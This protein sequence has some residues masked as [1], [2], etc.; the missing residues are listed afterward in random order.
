MGSVGEDDA[1]RF[2]SLSYL[3]SIGLCAKKLEAPNFGGWSDDMIPYNKVD[4]VACH[5]LANLLLPNIAANAK[6]KVAYAI[7]RRTIAIVSHMEKVGTRIDIDAVNILAKEVS[8]NVI[9]LDDEI[10]KHAPAAIGAAI[11]YKTKKPEA[12]TTAAR[13]GGVYAKS[14][15]GKLIFTGESDGHYNYRKIVAFNPS[16]QEHRVAALKHI[17][18]WVPDKFS[19]KTGKP[20]CDKGVLAKL[21]DEFVFA[22]MLHKYS[23]YNKLATTYI[24]AFTKTDMGGR[25]HPSFLLT[26]TRTSRL[27]SRNPN[28]QNIPKDRCRSLIVASPGHKLVCV[29]L[30]QIELRILAWL[31]ANLINNFYLWG[32]YAQGADVHSSNMKLLETTNRRLAKNGIFLKIYGGGAAKLAVTV[33]IPLQLAVDKLALM[34]ERMPFIDELAACV[35]RSAMTADGNTIYTM[36]GHKLC[37]PYLNSTDRS[38]AAYAKRQYF[39]AIIQGTQADIIKYIM[40]ILFHERRITERFGARFLLQIHDELVFEVPEANVPLVSQN[41]DEVCNNKTMLPGLPIHGVSGWGDSWKEASAHSEE[42]FDA[43]KKDLYHLTT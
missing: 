29:D 11:R 26:A 9:A 24:P 28:F 4:C 12:D 25:T 31:S 40:C 18:G 33:G 10:H 27:S 16:A 20:T 32:L 36:Y 1:M 3:S 15:V 7:D 8:D 22:R 21:S 5:Q 17:C 37:Y 43:Y 19:K 14:D 23:E 34:N 30:S 41:I 39:N 38:L 6:L 13:A 2:Y 35:I 42:R